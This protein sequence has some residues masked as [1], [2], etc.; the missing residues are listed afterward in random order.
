MWETVIWDVMPK[1]LRSYSL[2]AVCHYGSLAFKRYD[3]TETTKWSHVTA[4]GADSCYRTSHE[5]TFLEE[6][7]REYGNT[8]CINTD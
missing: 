5:V 6:L 7:F 4:R 8:L 3:V 2:Q 1:N